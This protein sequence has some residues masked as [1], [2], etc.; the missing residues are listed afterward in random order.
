ML[1][2]PIN[3]IEVNGRKT[4]LPAASYIHG[5]NSAP[6]S[7]KSLIEHAKGFLAAPYLWGGKSIWGCDCSGFVQVVY[8]LMGIQLPRDAYQQAE[9]GDTIEFHTMIE[10][11]DLAYFAKEDGRINHVGICMKDGKIIHASGEVR[12]DSLDQQGIFNADLNKYTHELRL[13]KRV[14]L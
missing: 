1:M 13:I 6:G 2:D 4:Y 5:T 3:E 7:S 12:I 14:L 8:K 11:G 9:L 10:E